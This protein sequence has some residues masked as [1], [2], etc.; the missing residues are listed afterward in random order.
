MNKSTVI[1]SLAYKF[2][3][4]FSVKAIG[5]VIS[6]ILARLLS[7]EHFGQL[8]ILTIFV[9]LSLTIINGGL[10]T[11]LVQSKETDERDYATVFY[12]CMAVTALM[13]VLLYFAAPLIGRFY[14]EPDIVLPLRVYS[15]TLFI[16]AFNSILMA[17]VQREMRFRQ[18]LVC[19]LI[20]TVISGSVGALLAFLGAGIWALVGYF[21]LNNLINALTLAVALR[22]FPHGRFSAA[23]AK[24]L[25]S[26]GL[27]MLA[28][29]LINVLYNDI[30]P[31]IIGKRF[32]TAD[33][34]Y[35]DRGGQFSSIIALNIDD[36][37]QS[38]MF[39]VLSQLQ[40]QRDALRSAAMRAMGMNAFLIFPAMFGMAAVAEPMVRL[41]LTDKWLPCVIFVQIL[42]IAEAQ[43]PLTTTNL[44][45]L[46]SLGR[47]DIYMKQEIVR[48]VLML[49]VL[50][51]SVFAFN[52]TVAI[53]FGFLFSAWLDA[54]V[55]SL[56]LKK[57][58]GLRFLDELWEL[59]QIAVASLAMFAVVFALNALPLPTIAKLAIQLI[60]GGAVYLGLCLA[61]KTPS[62]LYVFNILKDK[63][64]G[65]RREN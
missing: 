44:V 33:L 59:W 10:N 17:R 5:L 21:A 12:I 54:F 57:L 4:R 62:L 29:S 26:F 22:W 32:S 34:G 46:K 35:Y 42:C 23:S 58:L 24:R 2:T 51:T 27:R 64:P 53:A 28:S 15:L 25:Y 47:S 19:S 6:I 50:L 13:I 56:P 30:R 8:A 36:A 7:P 18:Q 14:N 1:R 45:V 31:L 52:S 38:V 20:A 11:A 61:L 37:V 60:S 65:G 41:L 48:R 9:D 63:L 3:E 55:T 39:P 16:S 43:I 49:A 40:D